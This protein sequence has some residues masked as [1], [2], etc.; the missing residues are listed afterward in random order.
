MESSERIIN[1]L[2]HFCLLDSKLKQSASRCKDFVQTY[3][4]EFLHRTR[5]DI[6]IYPGDIVRS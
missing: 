4:I 2:A 6:N 1:T 5:P 3:G